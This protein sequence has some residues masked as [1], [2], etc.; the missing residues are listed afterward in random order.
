MKRNRAKTYTIHFEALPNDIQEGIQ[1]YGITNYKNVMIVWNEDDKTDDFLNFVDGISENARKEL[2]LV[3]HQYEPIDL[4]WKDK[5]PL[6]FNV[7]N[8]KIGGKMYPVTHYPYSIK[9]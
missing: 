6:S 8:V 5:I 9:R 1:K 2:L 7:N 4:V 3:S